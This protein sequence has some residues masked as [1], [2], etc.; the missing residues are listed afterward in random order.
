MKVLSSSGKDDIATVYLGQFENNKYVEFV[1]SV[2]PPI[3]RENK[4]VLIIST[5]FGC[6]IGCPIC[7]AGGFYK[8]KL[9]KEQLLA[10]IDYLVTKRYPDKK[11]PAAKFKIQFARMGD[12]AFNPHIIEL[13]KE[14]PSLYDAPGLMPCIS[15]V[16]PVSTDKFF[17]ELLEVK[18][19]LY[20]DSFQMQFSI[21]T[22]DIAQRDRLIPVKK[23]NFT[24]IAE[25]GARF[26]REGERKI[27]LNFALAEGSEIDTQT[28]IS[29]FD[30]EIFLIKVT[31]VNP[32]YSSAK[33]NIKS[34]INSDNEQNELMQAIKDAGY[35]TI[36]SIGELKENDIGSNCGQYVRRH[37]N[38]TEK[39]KA[40]YSIAGE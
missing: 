22:T 2:Q 9:T 13:L 14:L 7:D 11:V 35:D 6:P 4:W 21:H 37:L 25:Y 12:P 20:N 28:L 3:P 19:E 33:N 31:P 15:T 23:W 39:M 18:Q 29:N 32:T 8:G 36:V 38:A 34:R 30:P 24:Q 16:A 40:A 10:Q 1:E 5:L 26:H 17:E 27:A